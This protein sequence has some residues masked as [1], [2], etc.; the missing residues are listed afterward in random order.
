MPGH[1]GLYLGNVDG[2]PVMFHN[3]WGVRVNEGPGHDDRHVIGK[4]VIT[5]LEPGKELP[6]L[7]N[8]QTLIR[9]IGGI[10]FLP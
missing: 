9:R 10:S 6:N 2:K 8:D 3:V 5:T 7:Y 1:I 4:A